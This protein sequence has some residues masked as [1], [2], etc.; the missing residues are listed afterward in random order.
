[1]SNKNT[2][3]NEKEIILISLS[4]T[5]AL[6]VSVFAVIR[7]FNQ[8]LVVAAFDAVLALFGLYVFA[9]VWRTRNVEMP[10]YA[11][12]VI[13]VVGT[14]ATI[15]LKGSGQIFW[16]FP[17]A[18]LVFY[19]LPPRHALMIWSLTAI[20][21]LVLIRELPGIQLVTI[22]MTFFITS[23]FCH[24]FS[25]KMQQ[26][27]DRLRDIANEDV[28][29][30]MKNR[31]AFNHDTELLVESDGIRSGILFDLDNF[32]EV[33][34]YLGHAK[35]DEVLQQTAVF[36]SDMLKKQH[37]LYRIGGDEFAILCID[38]DFNYSY[39]LAQEI[40]RTFGNSELNK[41]HNIT[42]SMAVA[43]MEAD[44]TVNDWLGRL[45]SAL[46]KAKRSGRNQIIKAIR[47]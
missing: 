36:V 28:M 4:L 47:H 45:D 5:Y 25:S 40:H 11:I 27:H 38:K 15:M 13:S 34:D 1:M 33:N 17:S 26:Q 20:V 46:Y 2:R 12:S 32:K 42:L 6:C 18:A 24:L 31:R 44:E 19:L 43:Q 37:Q 7:F 3:R 9:V 22:C 16:A 10:S 29:T 41:Q 21:I 39:Q 8:E 30:K 23:F 35:G 14:M